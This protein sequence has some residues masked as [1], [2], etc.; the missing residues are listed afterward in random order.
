MKYLNPMTHKNHRKHADKSQKIH[1]VPVDNHW[2]DDDILEQQS[3]GPR[4]SSSALYA[5]SR[6]GLWGLL[7]F[8]L[9]SVAALTVQDFNIYKSFPEA[10][11]QILGC[12]LPAILV[13]LALTGYSFTVVVPVL[14]RMATGESPV[15]RWYHLFC[16][17]VFF[18]FYLASMTLPENF[19]VVIIIGVLLY[20]VEQAGIWSYMYKNPHGAEVSN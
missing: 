4:L 14:I 8:L 13:H 18:L 6:K 7:L 15:V 1:S 11:L 16:R 10:V 9:A 17:S 5:L 2:A 3:T 19:V 20:A 12:P